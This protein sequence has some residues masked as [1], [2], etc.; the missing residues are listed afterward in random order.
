MKEKLSS[1]LFREASEEENDLASLGKEVKAIRQ[2]REEK[3]AKWHD[4]LLN[5]SDVISVT[6]FSAQ[7]KFEIR[8]STEHGIID[9]F[10]KANKLLIRKSNNWKE[11]GIN[12]IKE[13]ILRS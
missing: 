5:S 2:V 8:T 3:F 6:K 13:N 10:P 11:K 4:E 1:K 7:G 9:Y 12:W